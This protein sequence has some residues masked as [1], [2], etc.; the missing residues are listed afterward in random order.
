MIVRNEERFLEGCLHSIRDVADEIVVG[1]TGST[2]RTPEIARDLG[3]KLYNVL[4]AEDFSAARNQVLENAKGIWILSIDADERLRPIPHSHIKPLLKDP[5]KIAYHVLMHPMPGWTGNWVVRLFRNDPRIRFKG[6][7]HESLWENLQSVISTD[8]K[9]IGFS[10][11]VLDHLGYD[12]D[13]SQ[14]HIRNLPFLLRETERDPNR[15]HIW[16]H[17]GLVYDAL[18]E[19]DLAEKAWNQ[20][21]ELVGNK[22][23][24]HIY[25]YIYYI[26]W[27]LRHG[28]PVTAM[29]NKVMAYCPDNP[30]F[31]W[32]KGRI[33]MDENRYDEAIP[34]FE[35]LISWGEKR[36]F[37]RLSMSYP[38]AIFDVKA[39]D[40]LAVCHFR[41]GNYAES[42][43]YF[44]LAE[45]FAPE[46]MEY[47][48]KT[49]LCE[50]MMQTA[51]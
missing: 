17:L 21:I 34:F 39:C 11:L 3:A 19:N 2:D 24:G 13:Q 28:K 43:R 27:R 20:S 16:S 33:L 49:Q 30:Y 36:D 14:K 29:L 12:N 9:T 32:L 1:D 31:Y 8:N 38:K 50:A 35:R 10:G 15:E 22:E 40:S 7:F 25:G 51:H 42:R 26:E 44:Q 48:V 4:W 41:L 46:C 45:K 5:K 23:G 37:N 6:I 47:K 18:G